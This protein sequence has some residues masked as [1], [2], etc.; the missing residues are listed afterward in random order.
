MTPV[1]LLK[2]FGFFLNGSKRNYELEIFENNEANNITYS[3]S[4]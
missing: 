4:E 1:K 3:L 2:Y